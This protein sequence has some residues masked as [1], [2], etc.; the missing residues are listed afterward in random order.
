MGPC[1]QRRFF[2]PAQLAMPAAESELLLLLGGQGTPAGSEHCPSH[3][4][5]LYVTRTKLYTRVTQPG[6]PSSWHRGIAPSHSKQGHANSDLPAP[7]CAYPAPESADAA[8]PNVSASLQPNLTAAECR[9]F[10]TLG[11]A[12]ALT[13][14]ETLPDRDVA[15]I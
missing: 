10:C 14:E 12:A 11:F 5:T 6:A 4:V 9:M 1:R 2:I 13:E 8:H 7:L 15:Q 3:K